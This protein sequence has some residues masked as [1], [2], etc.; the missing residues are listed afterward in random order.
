MVNRL[1]AWLILILAPVA[2]SVFGFHPPARFWQVSFNLQIQG[3]YR[4]G[5]SNP[6]SGYYCLETEWYGF[7]EEDD[8]DFIIYH[9]G[10]RKPHWLLT[11]NTEQHSRSTLSL[12]IPPPDL[13][14]DYI[15]GNETEIS[16]YYSL[17]PEVISH[18]G[19]EPLWEI[20]L[21]MPSIP[22]NRRP[23]EEF[24]IKSQVLGTRDISFSREALNQNEV[25][26]TFSWQEE[27]LLSRASRG[28]TFQKSKLKVTV[29]LR[30]I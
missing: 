13:K 30:K 8:L 2:G 14:L 25:R 21:L 24:Q 7:L 3:E 19:Q 17:E 28:L 1:I 18:S 9:L 26:K 5:G 16:F 27:S 29:E 4:L 10:T 22:W 11:A 6:L 12:L 23:P 15:E 20:N